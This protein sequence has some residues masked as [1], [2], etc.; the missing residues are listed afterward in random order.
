MTYSLHWYRWQ[1]ITI[2]FVEG[3]ADRDA[4]VFVAGDSGVYVEV[5]TCM[6]PSGCDRLVVLTAIVFF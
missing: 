2:E 1:P 4:G 6:P 3:A 5:P